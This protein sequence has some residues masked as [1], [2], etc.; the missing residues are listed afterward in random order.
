M[1]KQNQ[2][3]GMSTTPEYRVWVSIKQRCYNPNYRYYKDY[4]G[5]GI[6]VCDRWLYSFVAFFKDMGK[7][8]GPK[9]T[10]ERVDNDGN[11]ELGNCKWVTRKEQQNNTR[12]NVQFKAISPINRVYISK[13]QNEFARRFNLSQGNINNCLY[14]RRQTHRGWKFT[15]Y[16]GN[17]SAHLSDM[18]QVPKS[19][20][21]PWAPADRWVNL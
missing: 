16:L 18:A 13:N 9:Y 19:H 5:R 20:V 2:I 3:H 7:R 11:Y 14:N 1:G 4:G 21:M 6:R 17:N 15:F 10:I 8:P 12:K